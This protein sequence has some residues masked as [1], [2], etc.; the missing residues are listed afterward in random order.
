[1]NRKGFTMIELL[2]VIVIIAVLSIIMIPNIMTIIN[3]NK[4]NNI[5]AF[6]NNV[7]S[8]AKAYI[9]DNKYNYNCDYPNVHHMEDIY[10]KVLYEEGYL[11]NVINP[12]TNEEVDLERNYVEVNFDC[13]SR[14]FFYEFKLR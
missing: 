3:K 6:E 12:N 14:M 1:M 4:E 7:I 13:D 5:K 2:M 9:S 10:L 8:A 11:S